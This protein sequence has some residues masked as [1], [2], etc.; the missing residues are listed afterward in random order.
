MSLLSDLQPTLEIL[1]KII[2][3]EKKTEF[4]RYLMYISI[5]GF[6][7]II[8]GWIEFISYH[9]LGVDVTFFIF[10]VTG[11]PDLSPVAEPVLFLSLWLIYLLP[12][13]AILIF[14]MGITP[15]IINWNKSYRSIG[16]IAI[17]LFVLTQ[18]LILVLGISNSQFIPL[19]WGGMICI[20]FVLASRILFSEA[21][22]TEL[23]NGL[24]GFG[25]LS[26]ILG[27]LATFIVYP[28]ASDLAMFVL[29][30]IFG[31]LLITVSMMTYWNHGR[32]ETRPELLKEST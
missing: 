3:F 13:I 28:V 14:T 6:I 2:A 15:G 4:N 22:L 12:V 30:L 31:L 18:I 27:L 21:K 32:K 1:D 10:G 5:V 11:N 19:V 7:G 17:G 20:G 29:C 25:V 8:G 23:R 24:L 9:F 16:F 26:L